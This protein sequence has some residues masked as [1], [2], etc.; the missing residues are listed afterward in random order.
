MASITLK[1]QDGDTK[2]YRISKKDLRA[3]K[4]DTIH[5]GQGYGRKKWSWLCW[6][7]IVV[8]V[9]PQDSVVLQ[10]IESPDA[11]LSAKQTG[12]LLEELTPQVGVGLKRGA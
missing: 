1:S 5:F 10:T 11:V 9:P 2:T 8:R 6:E 4:A 3:M 12:D 7:T